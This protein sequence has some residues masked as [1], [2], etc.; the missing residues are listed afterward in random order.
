MRRPLIGVIIVLAIAWGGLAALLG[1]GT[2]PKL[3][4]DLQGGIEALLIAP[5]GTETDKLNV[6]AEIIRRRIE[7]IGGV[8][9]PDIVPSPGSAFSPPSLLVQ[10]PGV[11]DEQRAIDAIGTTGALSFRPVLGITAGAAGPLANGGTLPSDHLAVSVYDGCY[12][13]PGG[14]KPADTAP[15]VDPTTGITTADDPT[16]ETYL[17]Y[18][19]S[20]LHLGPAI[21]QGTQVTNAVAQ[22]Q[23]QWLVNLDLSSE[24]GD[25]FACMTGQATNYSDARREIAIVLDGEVRTAPPVATTV[26]PEGITGGRAVITI[27]TGDN[28]QQEARDL[29][30]VLRYGSLPVSFADPTE[31]IT[32]VSGTLGSDSLRI[33]LISG[34]AGLILVALF[35]LVFYRSLGVVAIIGLTVFGS[36]LIGIFSLFGSWAG[37][38]LTLAGVTGIIVSIGITADSYIVYFER[39]KDEIRTGATMATAAVQGFKGAF[40]TILTADFVSLLA[41]AL[42]YALAVGSVKGFAL[43]LGIATLLDMFVARTF[44]RR[45]VYLLAG[46]RWGDGGWFSMRGAAATGEDE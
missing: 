26:G 9:E 8:Q 12:S 19:G 21:V 22:F 15:V 32:Q 39:V 13:L 43:S 17:P 14:V 7:E 44:T 31:N 33:G 29:A 6:A 34:V 3:G 5:E 2:T 42:L 27:G 4:L 11:K 36:L 23:N 46:T 1:T 45:L 30:V 18:Q 40:R 16:K 38:T 20:V 41:A 35:L 25:R 28:S 24:G 10:L 37:L